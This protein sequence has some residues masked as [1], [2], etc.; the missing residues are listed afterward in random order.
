M[1]EVM[2]RIGG[3]RAWVVWAAAVS[4]YILSIFHRTSLAVAGLTA[5]ERFDISAAQLAT[6]TMVQLLVYAGMQLPVGVL[7]D[8]LGSRRMLAIGLTVMT[9]GQLSF[10]FASTFEAGLASRVLV[11]IGDSMVFVSVL[12]LVML[13]FPPARSPIVT[14][15]TALLGQLG[16]I[17]AAIPMAHA[18]TGFGWTTTFAVAATVGVVLGV[19]LYAVVIDSPYAAGEAQP[20]G[21]HEVADNVRAAW[22]H[23]GTRL[24][25]WTHF[26]TQFSVVALGLLWGFP[27]LV[28]GE[29]QSE[30]TA[31]VLLTVMTVSSMV[32]GPLLGT[33]V[34][35]YPF[36]RSTLV[37]G[38][39]SAIVAAWTVVLA[40]PGQAPLSLLVAL[41]V[42]VGIG[43]PSSMVGFDFAR[44]F[45]PVRR[46]SSATGIV[47]I[48][49]FAASLATIL[50]IGVVLDLLTPGG[51]SQ[52]SPDAFRWA[53]SFQYVVW[54]VGGWQIWRYRR[55]TRRTLAESDPDAYRQLR[56]G[57]AAVPASATS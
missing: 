52:Y 45:N 39:V 55:R 49:G 6:F 50:G 32:F 8:R 2:Y 4:I 23:P 28:Q 9:L 26:T 43:G 12:R 46:L 25:L 30:T 53:M 21:L 16:M 51:S 11:G 54:A 20:A 29:G 36:N 35:R 31:G 37:L 7:L 33:V 14:Q 40:W 1:T 5:A 27:F 42:V 15:L 19:V 38:I 10:A 57:V 34:A 18:L 41:M 24:G 17:A 22:A 56:A 47:N 48:G 44:T 13:W 3:R